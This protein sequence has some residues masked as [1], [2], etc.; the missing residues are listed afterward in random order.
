VVHGFFTD[1]IRRVGVP[2]LEEKLTQDIEAELAATV[3]K[4]DA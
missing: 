1:I 2:E 4:G 3:G